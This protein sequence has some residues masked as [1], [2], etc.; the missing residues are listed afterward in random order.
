[1][2]VLV[3][4]SS[5]GRVAPARAVTDQLDFTMPLP[6]LRDLR[7]FELAALDETGYLFTLRSTEQP[8]VRLFVVPPEPYFPEYAP[9][10]DPSTRAALGLDDGD[11]VLL[12][13]VHPGRAGEPPTA[14]LLAPMAV[15][16]RTGSAVQV[17]LD[18]DEWPLRAPLTASSSAA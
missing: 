5:A 18:G 6:G 1:M 13:V 17:V 11:A 3:A 12:V 2:S 9:Q 16:P 8:D 4:V 7:R 15:N 10:I 14:N